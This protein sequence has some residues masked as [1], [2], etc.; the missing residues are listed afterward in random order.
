MKKP[1][2]ERLLAI[3]ILELEIGRLEAYFEERGI[4][5]DGMQESNCE[6]FG[7]IGIL[8]FKLRTIVA[9]LKSLPPPVAPHRVAEALEE[10]TNAMIIAHVSEEMNPDREEDGDREEDRIN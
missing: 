8:L 10:A 4:S 2:T 7:A 3:H 1:K 5:I 6:M 9:E